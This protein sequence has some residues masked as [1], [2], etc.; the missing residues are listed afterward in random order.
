MNHVRDGSNDK[1][2]AHLRYLYPALEKKKSL[3][4]SQITPRYLLHEKK[5][6]SVIPVSSLDCMR[7]VRFQKS[8]RLNFIEDMDGE[9][10]RTDFLHQ[11][12]LHD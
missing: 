12:R 7:S 2:S 3:Q 6:A 4:V 11:L 10:R 8:R 5:N 9:I 1:F